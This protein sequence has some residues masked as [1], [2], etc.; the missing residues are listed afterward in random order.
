MGG[1][2]TAY[3]GVADSANRIAKLDLTTGA[4]DTTFS[5][6]SANGFNGDVP[7]LTVS[8]TSLYV[9]GGFTA[10]RGVANSANRIAKLNLSTGDLDP[11]FSPPGTNG[12]DGS[13]YALT[14]SDTSLYVGGSFTR[15]RGVA[16]SAK[17]IA[18]LN[19]ST[20][21]LDPTFSP[22][23]ANGFDGSVYTLTVSGTSVY[24]GGG[25]TAY[26]GV[27]DSAKF[28]A[29]LNLTTGAL[30]PTFSPPGANGFDG[31]IYALTVSGT[32]LYVAGSFTRYRGSQNAQFLVPLDLASGALLDP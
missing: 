10:Y 21:D 27:A 14:V 6:P 17:S 32:S 1:G 23:G 3:R 31:S 25:F 15:Y 7:A 2:F 22:P 26:R 13:V 18:K 9:G 30:N 28:I 4:L 24:V 20:G 19:L 29:K 11:T 12:F 5:P 8:G 16:D